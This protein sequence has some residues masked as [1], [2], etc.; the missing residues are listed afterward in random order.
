MSGS[1]STTIDACKGQRNGEREQHGPPRRS[2]GAERRTAYGA[3][4]AAAAGPRES[5]R[6][7]R[8]RRWGR[9]DR[10]RRREWPRRG[11]RHRDASVRDAR[12]PAAQRSGEL[13]GD[14]QH[15]GRRAG[16]G[17][18]LP[19]GQRARTRAAEKER[20]RG[21]EGMAQA[22]V[23]RG[24]GGPLEEHLAPAS[25]MRMPT[26]VSAV[27]VEPLI[28]I[29]FVS[30]SS[31]PTDSTRT[32]GAQAAKSSR[33]TGG[34]EDVAADRSRR[35]PVDVEQHADREDAD[36]VDDL[37]EA[38]LGAAGRARAE[39][40]PERSTT[41]TSPMSAVLRT[42][43][44]PGTAVVSPAAVSASVG[45]CSRAASAL[46]TILA[47]ARSRDGPRRACRRARRRSAGACYP[48]ARWPRALWTSAGA[49]GPCAGGRAG[50]RG[51]RSDRRGRRAGRELLRRTDDH[52]WSD[53]RTLQPAIDSTDAADHRDEWATVTTGAGA[54]ETAEAGARHCAP[55]VSPLGRS[56]RAGI[57]RPSD[58][59]CSHSDTGL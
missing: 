1:P 46:S 12:S 38:Q 17:L 36:R 52:R 20:G 58:P 27:A 32:G 28:S 48:P 54:V 50:G 4:P 33:V 43:V 42:R 10:C 45:P 15:Q 26:P 49:P 6:W 5:G 44:R 39:K 57:P 25:L 24:P 13:D 41:R 55:G 19:D 40:E 7:R 14:G 23:T 37:G 47:S 31:G 2:S 35:L 53:A 59:R 21:A 11:G 22:V 56:S 51:A 9:R 34:R 29:P 30:T 18:E 16:R 3:A 8:R